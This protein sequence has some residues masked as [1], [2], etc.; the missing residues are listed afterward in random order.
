MLLVLPQASAGRGL[1][2]GMT[3]IVGWD[4]GAVVVVELETRD[5]VLVPNLR[6]FVIPS[7]LAGDVGRTPLPEWRRD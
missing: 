4:A 1:T 3:G 5:D 2:I 7:E 6:A